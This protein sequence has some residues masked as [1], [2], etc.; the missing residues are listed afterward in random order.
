[1]IVPMML[2]VAAPPP[3][4]PLWELV[5]PAPHY[6]APCPLPAARWK[7]LSGEERPF[8]RDIVSFDGGQL[9]WNGMAISE[10]DLTIIVQHVA[11]QRLRAPI[12]LSGVGVA[13]AKLRRIAAL[14]ATEGGCTPAI[15]WVTF[16]ALPPQPPMVSVAPPP[17]P[18][19]ANVL[20]PPPP[21]RSY[22][23]PP[24]QESGGNRVRPRGA[25]QNWV[26]NDD[27][28]A[29]ALRVEASGPV[30]FRLD[31]DEAG[32]VFA[33]TV[34]SS[35]G[36][37][38]LDATTCALLKRRAQFVPATDAQGQPVPSSWSSRLRWE[39]PEE[40]RVP[41]E[42]WA[43]TLRFTISPNGELASCAYQEYGAPA[44]EERSPCVE[45][46]EVPVPAMRRLRGRSQGPVTI[47]IRFDHAV[48]GMT[49]PKVPALSARF[50]PIAV[51]SGGY[52][53]N[54]YGNPTSCTGTIDD[55]DLP[56][57]AVTCLSYTH[58]QAPGQSYQATTT[59]SFFTDG[60]P[61]V[62]VALPGLTDLG[63]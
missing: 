30:A 9:S 33:C 46:S 3:A 28:P 17:M 35:S 13:C 61:G 52:T 40:V 63:D 14:I 26:T 7:P 43:S 1:M 8:S 38:I 53:I 4:E 44:I 21:P 42:S 18:V 31:I 45:I 37:D 34:T 19:P 29:A 47:V 6:E 36:W 5:P 55:H 62:A 23:P 32:R 59:L 39:L 16:K 15:C 48:A 11:S 27:Y 12:I 54:P 22:A 51:W 25:P 50:K 56:V 58:Y 57:P 2:A 60:D 24:P 10:T 20:P 41:V 49:M